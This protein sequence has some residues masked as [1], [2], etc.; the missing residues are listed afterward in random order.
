MLAHPDT[1]QPVAFKE[2]ISPN[3]STD[4]KPRIDFTPLV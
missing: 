3:G 4:A 2:S 1:V